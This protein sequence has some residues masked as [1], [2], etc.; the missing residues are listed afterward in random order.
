MLWQ[1]SN[2]TSNTVGQNSCPQHCC[3][4]IQDLTVSYSSLSVLKNISFHIH[5]G[6]VL[7]LVGPNGSGKTTLL[8]AILGEI[9]YT[10]SINF[11]VGQPNNNRSLLGYVP[12]KLHFDVDSPISVLDLVVLAVSNYPVFFKPN[13]SLRTQLKEILSPFS[14]EHLLDRKI[15]ELSG[16]EMQRVLLAI[17]MS[18]EPELLL[19]DEPASGI[20]VSG[21]ELFY[22][23]V[24]HLREKHHI[25]VILVTHDLDNMT[26]YI[27][28]VI[29]LPDGRIERIKI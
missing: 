27:D 16:G 6:E 24:S 3:I 21:R 22:E 10:G 18:A 9:S 17:A 11:R 25:A 1:K 15:G 13:N 26:K 19:L 12:Q 7:A 28:R 14:A 2:K 5:C 20:D 29:H 8:K 4:N 23:T